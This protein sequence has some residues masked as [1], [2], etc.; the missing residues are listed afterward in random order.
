MTTLRGSLYRAARLL[1]DVQAVSKGPAA[2]GRR[3][4]RKQAYATWNGLL[5]GLLTRALGGG[6]RR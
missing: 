4:V 5:G 3:I 2:T 1:G 6:R